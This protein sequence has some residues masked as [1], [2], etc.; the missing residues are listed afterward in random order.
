MARSSR[1]R[2]TAPVIAGLAILLM[3]ALVAPG[4]AA[5]AATGATGAGWNASGPGVSEVSDGSTAAPS[6][7]YTTQS[8]GKWTFLRTATAPGR[9]TLP[10]AWTGDHGRDKA[11]RHLSVGVYKGGK[12]VKPQVLVERTST[13]SEPT[14]FKHAGSAVLDVAAGD[15]YG[16]V[17]EGRGRDASSRLTGRL[18]LPDPPTVTV[19]TSPLVAATQDG[20]GTAV[21]FTASAQD[22]GDGPLPVTCTPASGAR[23][24]IGDTTVTCSATSSTQQT[25]SKT[26]V[27]RVILDQ[28]NIAWPKATLMG[29]AD[30][31]SDSISGLDQALWY[32]FPVQPDSRVEVRLRNLAANYDLTL[33]GDIGRAF[34]EALTTDDLQRLTAEFASDAFSPSAFSP[35]AFSPS[36]FSPSAFSPSAFSPSAFSP[37]A[38]SPSAFSPSAFSPSAFSP[39]AFSPS[40]FSPS[41]FSPAVSLPSAFSPSAFSPSAFSEA[42]LVD[43]FRSAQVRTLIAVSARDG[44]ADEHIR[45]N[46]WGASGFFYV[47]VQGRNGAF[48]PGQPFTVSTTSSNGACAAPLDDFESLATFRGSP[49][50]ARTV[51]LTDSSRLPGAPVQALEA[52]AARPD[53]DGVV[54]DGAS[55]PRVRALQDQADAQTACPYAKNLVAQELRVVDN[56]YRDGAG[57]LEYVVIAGDDDVVPFFRSADAAGL[58][59]ESGYVPPV[60][61]ASPSQAALRRNMVLS[62]DAYGARTDVTLK[63]ASLPVA[64]VAVGRLV[65]TPAEI[66]DALDRYGALEGGVLPPPESALVTGYDFLTDAAD[67]VAGHLGAA[68]GNGPVDEL[69][70]DRD[71]SPDQTTQDGAPDRRHSWTAD[72]LRAQLIGKRH[73]ILFMAGHFSA[74]SALAADNRS[75]LLTTEILDSGADLR[76]AL[77]MSIGCHS[78]YNIVD[79]H[80]IPGLTEKLDWTQLM[81][82]EGAVFI[83]GTGYQY[84]DTDLLEYS[85]R[86]YADVAR[87]LRVGDGPVPVGEA[88]LRAKQDYLATTPVI[89]GIHQK[90]LL[91][92]ALYGLPMVGVDLPTGR[93]TDPVPGTSSPSP[94]STGPGSVLGLHT[95]DLTAGGAT[96]LLTQPFDDLDGTGL[97]EFTYLRGPDGVTTSPGQPALPLQSM[98][99]GVP[100]MALRG[101]AFRGGTYADIAG[102]VPLTGAPATDISEVHTAFSSPTFF[103][104]RLALANTYGAIAGDGGTRLL[105]TPAQHRSDSGNTSTLRRYSSLDLRLLYSGNTQQYGA[106]TPALAAPP[107]ISSVTSTVT[108]SQV[109]VAA[110]VVGDPSAG[111]HQVWVTRTAESGPW[112]GEWRSLD[113]QQD[114][115]DST[116]WRGTMTLPAGQAPG[117][118]RFVV[119]ASNGVGLVTLEDNQGREFTP[120]VDPASLPQAGDADST[121]TLDAPGNAVLGD[122]I[123]VTARLTGATPLDGRTVLFSLGGATSTAV[124]DANGVAT[125]SFPAVE[126]PGTQQLSASFDGDQALRPAGA[127]RTVV[128]AKRPTTLV[129]SGGSEPV[130]VG[131]DT[132]V[133][134]VLRSGGTPVTDRSVIVVARDAGGAVVAAATRRT[135][136][137]GRAPLGRLDLPPGPITLTAFFGSEGVPVGGG[138]TAGSSDPENAASTSAPLTIEVREGAP[139]QIVTTVLPEA[140][141]G[142][143]YTATIEVTGDPAPQVAVTGLPE[144]L[145]FADGTISGSTTEVGTSRVVVTATNHRGTAERELDLTVLAGA[146]VQLVAVSGGGQG[147]T[148]GTAFPDPLVVRV[149]DEWGSPVS[150]VTVTFRS[151]SSGPGTSPR[152]STVVTGEAGRAVL[153]PV[154]GSDVGAYTVTATAGDAAPVTFRLTNR[155]ALSPFFAPFTAEEGAEPISLPRTTWEQ[156]MVEVSDSNGRL[157]LL[158]SLGMS[159][160]CQVT[161]TD[162]GPNGST[163]ICM[164]YDA[165]LQRFGARVSGVDLGWQPG[166]EHTLRVDVLGSD[167]E[168]IGRREVRVSVR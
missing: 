26:F 83:G 30:E 86:L 139:P 25:I 40:A 121:L 129:L 16:F 89:S 46:T 90:A 111:I 29:G 14:S 58:G 75:A 108:G 123:P 53:I 116:L 68:L 107:A 74:N 144:G 140:R 44:L 41:A 154:A 54:V 8:Q 91:E 81:A 159:L 79:G 136:P 98:E 96:T 134:A 100:G 97:H 92:A 146:P 5:S 161:L 88:L 52:F 17:L 137:D 112:H 36:A 38:F 95:L 157:G 27:V 120:G 84:G 148:F 80:G 142:A 19:P 110:H 166:T 39:S 35:S 132:G 55:I 117:E 70:T 101:V 162:I 18:V 23:F 60:D 122:T 87:Q 24:P 105:V 99:V 138:E 2:R 164:G 1:T 130:W 151:P 78:G 7:R 63:G 126:Q 131:D 11:R 103:P 28:R 34:D 165:V 163:R 31:R 118:V 62:Q 13:G 167:S 115:N 67:E 113:L 42:D 72:D 64:D 93:L 155:L 109:E 57:P 135:G 20:T 119:Q 114:A 48:A 158:T 168:V 153:Q 51:V 69:I 73:D 76:D 133:E 61:D 127:E 59:P 128:V 49:G 94:V 47:R 141:S 10:W 43:A 56:S 85:E 33:F 9:I 66:T 71:V 147:T 65:E 145:T 37:S 3:L 150:G 152:T 106:N 124:T 45:V 149:E 6:F 82:R 143:P 32:R 22:S 125:T 50:T 77:V 156:L 12:L 21:T 102:V 104:R 160:S 15:V 4:G